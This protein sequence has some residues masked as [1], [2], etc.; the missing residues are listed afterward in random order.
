M[1][2]NEER[3]LTSLLS[4]VSSLRLRVMS[5]LF[6]LKCQEIVNIRKLS[7]RPKDRSPFSRE[8]IEMSQEGLPANR[9]PTHLSLAVKMLAK[10]IP[11]KASGRNKP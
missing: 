1:D 11:A 2:L 10:K 5:R 7:C 4:G 8:E 9:M 3:K 6:A